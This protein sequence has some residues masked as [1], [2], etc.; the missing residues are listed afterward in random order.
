MSIQN[1]WC[2]FFRN[3]SPAKH[4]QRYTKIL[5]IPMGKNVSWEHKIPRPQIRLCVS[6]YEK[7]VFYLVSF[8]QDAAKN[9]GTERITNV[10]NDKRASTGK[11]R[12][13]TGWFIIFTSPET[14]VTV[15]LNCVNHFSFLLSFLLLLLL[16]AISSVLFFISSTAV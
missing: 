6:I 8:G 5:K 13:W 3:V 2:T 16:A 4:L 14:R 7:K 10:Y 15:F 1:L 9:R 12:Y 11:T